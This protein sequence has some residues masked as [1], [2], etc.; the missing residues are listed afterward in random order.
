MSR[1]QEKKRTLG[2]VVKAIN[3][4]TIRHMPKGKKGFGI[5]KGKTLHVDG[6]SSAEKAA[7]DINLDKK[8]AHRKQVIERYDSLFK[9][10]SDTND[11]S[12]LYEVRKE[13]LDGTT[14]KEM[15]QALKVKI[16]GL[17]DAN[18]FNL[19][20]AIDSNTVI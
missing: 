14:R 8:K 11:R 18:E 9:R 12:V 17:Q 7:D 3:G 4:Y 5:Y 16:R 13:G 15:K 2:A 10:L 6:Y 20:E 1:K 19:T